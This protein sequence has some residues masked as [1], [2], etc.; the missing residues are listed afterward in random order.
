MKARTVAGRGEKSLLCD[1]GSE[2]RVGR[3]ERRR[4]MCEDNEW[5]EKTK[6]KM[7]ALYEACVLGGRP[8]ADKYCVIWSYR[9]DVRTYVEGRTY[10]DCMNDNNNHTWYKLPVNQYDELYVRRTT[11]SSLFRRK[12]HLGDSIVGLH[13][14]LPTGT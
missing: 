1:P 10:V 3:R 6:K 9:R 5:D 13:R 11:S 14:L 12:S 8:T 7:S 4:C 2:L